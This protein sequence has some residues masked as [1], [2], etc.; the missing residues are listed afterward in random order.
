M[1]AAAQ[2]LGAASEYKI[3][4]IGL[5]HSHVWGHLGPMLKGEHAKLAGITETIAKDLEDYVRIAVALASDVTK[6]SALR[7][8]LRQRVAASPLC[9]GRRF[10]EHFAT[11]LREA[12]RKWCQAESS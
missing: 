7:A 3:A 4:V 6:L 11:L 9:D 12:W 10:A 2:P 5:V 1:L 8:G